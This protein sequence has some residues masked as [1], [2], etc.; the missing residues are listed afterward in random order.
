MSCTILNK[1]SNN[2]RIVVIVDDDLEITLLFREALKD[3]S[4]VKIFTFT[5]PVLALEHFQ[6]NEYAYVLVISDFKMPGL[7]GMEFLKKIKALNP[8]VRT[9]LMTAFEVEDKI[10]RDYTKNKIIDAFLQ[11]PIGMHDL[12]KEVDTQLHSYENQKRLPS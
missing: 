1:V 5:D 9:I 8:F 2:N 10:F 12:I 6:V 3:I 4:R 7:N 11:K